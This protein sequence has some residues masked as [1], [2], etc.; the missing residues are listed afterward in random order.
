MEKL[1]EDIEIEKESLKIAQTSLDLAQIE[2]VRLRRQADE[3]VENVQERIS[4]I[5]DR[6]TELEKKVIAIKCADGFG[7]ERLAFVP[8]ELRHIRNTTTL[9]TD[10]KSIRYALKKI[11]Y[12]LETDGNTIIGL[13]TPTPGVRVVSLTKTTKIPTE[14]SKFSTIQE[15][16]AYKLLMSGGDFECLYTE[17]FPRRPD[18]DPKEKIPIFPLIMNVKFS[19]VYFKAFVGGREGYVG[20]ERRFSDGVYS[21][22][23]AW[24]VI[25]I[26][27]RTDL[28]RGTRDGQSPSLVHPGV[29]IS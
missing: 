13:K 25:D 20:W 22:L 21:L 2:A 1:K 26:A 5:K 18:Q 3:I 17:K 24:F 10:G 27:Q 4:I 23:K 29:G 7:N 6:L 28:K 19:G 11:A 16:D 15:V 8:E 9:T 14:H 12:P